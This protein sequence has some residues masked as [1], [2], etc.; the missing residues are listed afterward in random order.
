MDKIGNNFHPSNRQRSN[1][2]TISHE[3]LL[4][5]KAAVL[6]L[7][8]AY[9]QVKSIDPESMKIMEQTFCRCEPDEMRAAV[10]EAVR[11]SPSFF[12]TE[13]I[14]IKACNEASKRRLED[15]AWERG[16]ARQDSER[17]QIPDYR[18]KSAA[19]R[20]YSYA[21]FER[22]LPGQRA[23]GRFERVPKSLIPDAPARD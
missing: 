3:V 19:V 17:M 21:E 11:I 12:P 5:A 23:V 8:A 20:Q 13:G 22:E 1:C 18:P 6:R 16:R 2:E 9:P 7:I 14:L 10:D 15:Q 4:A